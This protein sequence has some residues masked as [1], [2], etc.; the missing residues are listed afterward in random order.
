MLYVFDSHPVQYRAPVFRRMSQLLDSRMRVFYATDCS[1]RGY[2]D[3]GFGQEICWDEP[4]LDGYPNEV[5]HCTRGRPLCGFASLTGR[6]L[7]R[8]FSAARPKC[9]LLTGLNYRY[10]WAAR[11]HAQR[12]GIPVWLR[13]ETQDEAFARPIWK[14][15]LRSLFYRTV[16]SG[17]DRFFTI[18]ELNARHYLRHGIPSDRLT[19]ARYATV[20]RCAGLDREEK[21]ALRTRLRT[22]IGAS[23]DAIIIGF[24]GKFIQKKDPG[25]LIEMAELLGPELQSR[26][27]LYFVGSGELEAYLQGR[28]VDLL[29]ET[30]V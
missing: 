21:V 13:Q 23:E 22:A 14:E 8:A 19:P 1:V 12:R 27:V 5:L 3:P 6:G 30:G 7:G 24:S 9:I 16:Y 11:L 10:D 2:R 15:C 17:I 4:L 28:A 25:I 18:G 26:T 20:D 29:R